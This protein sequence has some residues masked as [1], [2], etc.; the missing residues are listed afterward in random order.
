MNWD[1]IEGNWKELAG[2]A[3]AHWGKLTDDD[4]QTITGKKDAAGWAPPRAIRTHKGG[5]AKASRQLV[6][7]PAGCCRSIENPLNRGVAGCG[8]A[9]MENSSS[10]NDLLREQQR[11]GRAQAHLEN[12]EL[13]QRF[14]VVFA[15]LLIA[16]AVAT[17]LAGRFSAGAI[18]L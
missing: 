15:V 9:A 5:S 13:L 18:R 6:Q 17:V 7:R 10:T 8:K 4:W 1:Q 2:S 11:A 16:I 12:R 14:A 3:R